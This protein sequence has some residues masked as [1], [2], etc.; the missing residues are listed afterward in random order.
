MLICLGATSYFLRLRN[1]EASE[2]FKRLATLSDTGKIFD[3][4]A[5]TRHKG[6][7][8]PPE[9]GETRLL[10]LHLPQGFHDIIRLYTRTTGASRNS[11]LNRFLEAGFIIYTKGQN[12]LLETIRSLQDERAKT[13]AGREFSH[14]VDEAR[15]GG[16]DKP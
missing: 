5:G 1:P 9:I 3:M 6:R 8:A 16:S 13:E 10:A 14:L 12:T 15:A 7:K 11:A 2:R 4:A